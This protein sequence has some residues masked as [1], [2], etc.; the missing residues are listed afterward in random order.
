MDEKVTLQVASKALNVSTKTIRRYIE[1]GIISKSKE[2]T[3]IFVPMD[4]IRNLKNRQVKMDK[5][6]P[7]H[8]KD[9][10]TVDRTHY[11]GL[12]TRLGQLEGER[13]YLLEYKAD[14]EKKD[15]EMLKIKN[16][17]KSTSKWILEVE[18]KNINKNKKLELQKNILNTKTLE[19]EKLKQNLKE[20]NKKFSQIKK[21]GLV[22]RL[23]NR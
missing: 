20:L 21:R 14:L 12:L 11:D 10:I 4:E 7:V 18:E 19:I 17:I 6:H 9:K 22:Q 23:L 15:E 16:N 3:R 1:R 5:Y 8:Q 2:G 13:K